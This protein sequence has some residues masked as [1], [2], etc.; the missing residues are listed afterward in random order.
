MLSASFV[1]ISYLSD[2]IINLFEYYFLSTFLADT[3]YLYFAQLSNTRNGKKIN[4]CDTIDRSV[5]ACSMDF[6]QD[7][8]P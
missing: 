4:M 5:Y 2:I 6:K 8:L 7:V 3:S 1:H